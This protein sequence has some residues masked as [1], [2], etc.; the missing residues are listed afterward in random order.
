MKTLLLF[1]IGMLCINALS[2]A[3]EQSLNDFK[4]EY[5]HRDGIRSF[6][7]PGFLV[8]LAGNIALK[9]EDCVDREALRPLLKNMGSVSL[10][11]SEGETRIFPRDIARLKADLLDEDYENLIKVRDGRNEIEVYAWEKKDIIRR[12]VF[13]IQDEQDELVLVNIRGYFSPDE[14]SK[15]VERYQED[16]GRKL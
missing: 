3:Q 12:V 16:R 15:V 7:V 2:T 8:R 1:L 13:F 10:F 4:R 11:L 6:T 9:E 5:H 14:I